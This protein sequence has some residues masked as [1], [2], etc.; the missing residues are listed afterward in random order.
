MHTGIRVVPWVN[1]EEWENLRLA[2]MNG[3]H[4]CAANMLAMYRLR[5]K[6]GVPLPMQATVE[7][8]SLLD[9][10][11]PMDPHARRLALAMAIV[12]LVNG[13]TDRIQPRSEN[14]TA[15][16]VH[17]LAKALKMPPMLVEIRHQ[18]SHNALPR[19]DALIEAS[20]EALDW[21]ETSYWAPQATAVVQ[22]RGDSIQHDN[23]ALESNQREAGE[24]EMDQEIKISRENPE[25]SA[26]PFRRRW[27]KCSNPDEWKNCPIGLLPGSPNPVNL[28]GIDVSNIIGKNWRSEEHVPRTDAE[29]PTPPVS[30]VAVD[31]QRQGAAIQDRDTEIV[32]EASEKKLRT[33]DTDERDAVEHMM[34]SFLG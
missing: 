34:R 33:L 15:R 31:I 17:S 22:Q 10:R 4:M 20:R 12:R 16:S 14:A 27:R 18:S 24:K 13:S 1:W 8:V 28:I 11:I 19:L 3:D 32:L 30:E 23:A 7:L 6:S 2:I 29:A 21:L 9:F 25:D 5:R 26:E